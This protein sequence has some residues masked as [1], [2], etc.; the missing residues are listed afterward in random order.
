MTLVDTNV[1]IDIL[2]RDPTWF[3]WSSEQLLR[4]RASGPL[5]INEISYAE[6]AARIEVEAALQGALSEMDVKFERTGMQALFIAGRAFSRYR[7]A[8]GPRSSILPD[9]FIGAH[10]QV[11]GVQLLTRDARRY[12]TYFPQ[13]QLIAPDA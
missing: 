4:C 7:R 13:V 11:A 3:G 1:I 8:G 10:A 2:A 12:R 5:W 6:L 9:F